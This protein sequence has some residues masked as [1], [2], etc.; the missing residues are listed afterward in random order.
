[1]NDLLNLL[2]REIDEP[3][4]PLLIFVAISGFS[5]ALLIGIINSAAE[6]VSNSEVNHTYFLLFVLALGVFLFA[7]R[8]VLNKSSRI[9]ETVMH[10][11]RY[12]LADKIRHT[13]LSTLEATGTAPIYA[14]LTQDTVVISNTASTMLNSIQSG[15]MIVFTTLYVGTISPWSFFFMVAGISIGVAYYKLYSDSFWKAWQVVSEKETAFFE[16]LGHILKGFKEVKINRRKNEGV[17]KNYAVVSQDLKKHRF[18]TQAS[19]NTMQIFTQ[20]LFYFLLGGTLFLLPLFHPEHAE[21][22]IKVTAAL[23]FISGPFEGIMFSMQMFDNAGN[24]ARNIIKLEAEL[25]QQLL[26]NKL[27]VAAQNQLSAFNLLPYYENIQL[28]NLSYSYPPSPEQDFIF[29]VGPI[30]LTFRKGEIVFI[31]GGNGSGKSTFLKLLTGLYPPQ[32]GRIVADVDVDAQMALPITPLNYQQYRNLYSTIFTDFHLF[33]KLY[34]VEGEINPHTVNQIMENMELPNEKV[35]FIKDHF[36]NLHLSSGQKKR[37]ALTTALM[38]DKPIYI[39][40]EVASDLDPDFRD[41][42]Y[43]ELLSELKERGK[44]V[45]VV[46]HDRHYW[47][48]PDRLIEMDNGQIRELNRKDIDALLALN[49]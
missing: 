16:K 10:K 21:D 41:K 11:M 39:F 15:I 13:E 43:Y 44:T 35:N 28:Q 49:K 12:K 29:T 20:A 6:F 34:G 36:T 37:L 30:N 38:E 9:V 19:Y 25:E 3:I 23:L 2:K 42:Y 46:S 40:D 5:N 26:A 45:I 47:N 31:T 14:R 1:M 33:D 32:T 4:R 7:K 22:T 24:S 27:N 48:V 8:Y 17:F 18:G